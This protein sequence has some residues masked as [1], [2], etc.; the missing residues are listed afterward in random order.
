MRSP[1]RPLLCSCMPIILFLPLHLSPKGGAGTN[2]ADLDQFPF[3]P[4]DALTHSPW[5]SRSTY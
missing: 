3:L 1:L 4:L 5:L 2:A